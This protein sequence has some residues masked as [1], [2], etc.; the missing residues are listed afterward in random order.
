MG[1]NMSKDASSREK[2]VGAAQQLKLGDDHFPLNGMVMKSKSANFLS[3]LVVHTKYANFLPGDERRQSWNE[4]VDVVKNMHINSHPHLKDDIE[5]AFSYVYDKKVLPSMRSIQFGGAPI[6]YAPNR[7]YNCAYTPIDNEFVFAEILFLLLGGTG[8]GYSVRKRHVEKLPAIVKPQGDRRFLIGD[9]IEGWA[10]SVRQLVYAYTRGHE[11]PRFDYRDVRP[12]G[13]LIKK[14]GG[15]APGPEKLKRCHENMEKVFNHAIGRKLK[16]IEVHDIVCFI[17]DCVLAGGIREAALISLFDVD[18]MHMMTCKGVFQ[19]DN[20]RTIDTYIDYDEKGRK[21]DSGWIVGCTLPD[22]KNVN[23]RV[24]GYTK[25]AEIQFKLTDK[26]GDW[27]YKQF[28]ENGALP[29]YYIQP[30]RGRANNSVALRRGTVSE[31]EF[32]KIWKMTEASGAGEPGIYW[33][34]DDDDGANPCVEIALKPNQFCNLTTAVVY[35][36]TTQEELN[37]R[38]RAAA[39]IG[40]LQASY[41]DFHYLRQIWKKTTAEEALLGVS[42]TGIASGNI[43]KLDLKEAAEVAVAENRRG[44]ELMGINPAARVTCIKPEGSGTLA[45]GVIGS[46]I[47]AAHGKFFIRN[48]RIKKSDPVYEFLLEKMPDFIEDDVQNPDDRAVVSIPMKA[49]DGI[50]TREETAIDLLERIKK[51]SEE[52]VMTGHIKGVNSH[53]VS[54]TVSVRQDEWGAVAAWMWENRNTYNGLSVLPYA[55]GNYKQAPF[56]E[57]DEAEYNKMYEAFP[58]AV[59]FT[60]INETFTE[61]SINHA[62]EN[63]ACAGGA[64]EI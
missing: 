10:D 40:T 22:K 48:N 53:N 7:I 14:T 1:D 9:S 17:A 6:E 30:Q 37:N 36:V 23:T 56:I 43:L 26:Y 32:M 13:S 4:C 54:A 35:D 15:R 52:W 59:D 24:Y 12:K 16:P 63:L 25:T 33:T 19:A 29:W 58:E 62:S 45:A 57:I 41:T 50:I 18:E 31:K 47:H 5:S 49:P 28:M 21:I 11:R 38:V 27:D 44:A 51:F 8:V 34:N 2:E 42:M 20:M 60:E 55:G 39:F 64:C 46:G 3:N 61:V